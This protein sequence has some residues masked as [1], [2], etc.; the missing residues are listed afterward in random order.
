MSSVCPDA[1]SLTELESYLK[2]AQLTGAKLYCPQYLDLLEYLETAPRDL[3][4]DVQEMLSGGKL[5]TH[6]LNCSYDE[7]AWYVKA[8]FLPSHPPQLVISCG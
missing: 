7:M 6:K 3:T 1:I 5:I 8:I 2:E 4:Y